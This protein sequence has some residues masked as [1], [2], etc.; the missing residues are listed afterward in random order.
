MSDDPTC[1]LSDW[2]D[3]NPVGT[4]V[5][6]WPGPR[7]GD[8]LTGRTTSVA[9]LLG[10]EIPSVWVH[11]SDDDVARLDKATTLLAHAAGGW[12]ACIPL[13][14]IQPAARPSDRR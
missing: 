11:V 12:S 6:Y 7:D 14:N 9:T 4:E 8:A 13:A 1:D 5:R 2:D 3:E 10:D